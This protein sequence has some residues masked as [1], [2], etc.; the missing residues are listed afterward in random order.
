MRSVI[1]RA[2]STLTTALMYP[3][4][5]SP[6]SGC[7][8][9]SFRRGKARGRTPR[10]PNAVG[11]HLRRLATTRSGS[12][13]AGLDRRGRGRRRRRRDS[14]NLHRPKVRRRRMMLRS[15][16]RHSHRRRVV[17]KRHRQVLGEVCG[18][19]SSLLMGRFFSFAGGGQ[20]PKFVAGF[21]ILASSCFR[22]YCRVCMVGIVH[23]PSYSPQMLHWTMLGSPPPL[24]RTEEDIAGLWKD[25]RVMHDIREF[26]APLPSLKVAEYL[27]N[28]SKEICTPTIS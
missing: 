16:R 1:F 19:R 17:G 7:G 13:S 6:S 23:S 10:Q 15:P 12:K 4:P 26:G 20:A 8:R 25:A 27:W 5:P 9:S 21:W 18:E 11:R 22:M 3:K 24:P 2:H 14:A 28:V